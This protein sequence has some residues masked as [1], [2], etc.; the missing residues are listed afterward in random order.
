MI[1]R[2][3]SLVPV[4]VLVG[5]ALAVSAPAAHAQTSDA[6]AAPNVVEVAAEDFAFRIPETLPSGWTT[7]RFENEGEEHHVLL[8]SRLPDGTTF[9]D[10]VTQ[11]GEPFNQIWY[12]LR[13]GEIDEQEGWEQL[14]AALPEWY[15]GL[16][17]MGGAGLVGPGEVTEATIHLEPG[18]Y[19]AECYMKTA[20]GEI[21]AMEG[22][23]DPV[24][25]TE[26][27]SGGSPPSPDAVVTLSNDGVELDGEPTAAR[28]TFEV[29]I[30]DQGAAFGHNAHLA[31]LDE[32][33]EPDDVLGWQNWMTP[34]GMQ[35]P[36][37]AN[38]VG[39]IQILQV[40][41]RGYFT[42]DLEAG[43][44]LLI[45]ESGVWKDFAVRR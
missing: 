33:T 45:S 10:Y 2:P 15:G 17:P 3:F 40:G 8:L 12:R 39:G 31:R 11:V 25:V 44:Y 22:M 18:D 29:R 20:D 19:V 5:A 23:A 27:S 30:A 6:A 16:R 42:T 36:A 34:D 35:A 21:H 24:T 28:Q 13:D 43:R 38:F 4:I 37:P 41:E 32:G 14:G 9:D 1:S 26:A 7:I